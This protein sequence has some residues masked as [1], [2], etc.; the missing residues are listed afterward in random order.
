MAQ[1][2]RTFEGDPAYVASQLTTLA[3]TEEIT[4]VRKTYSSGSF[5]VIS[6]DTAGTG[7]DVVV[8]S[9]APETLVSTINDMIADGDVIEILAPT[10]SAS[11]Y[12]VVRIA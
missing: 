5:I 11:H 4:E 1:I 8:I 10:F 12:L 7:Q 9:G 3:A 6:D 2:A